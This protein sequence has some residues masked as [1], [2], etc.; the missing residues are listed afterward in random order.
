MLDSAS[1]KEVFKV[2]PEDNPLFLTVVFKPTSL[3]ASKRKWRLCTDSRAT[4]TRLLE[5][6]RRA[7]VEK[8]NPDV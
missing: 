4:V 6:V 5:E 2:Y 3:F 7:C 8:G 1:L